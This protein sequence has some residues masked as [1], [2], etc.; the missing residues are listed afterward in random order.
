MEKNDINICFVTDDNYAKNVAI[1]ITSI[2]HNKKD[3]DSL[4]FYVI[5]NNI[6]Q[7]NKNIILSSIQKRAKLDFIDITRSKIYNEIMQL[8]QKSKYITKSSYFKFVIADILCDVDKVIYLDSDLIIKESLSDLYNVDLE[9]YLFGAVEDMGYTYWQ[10]HSKEKMLDFLCINSGVL[11]IDCVKWREQNLSEQLI[12]ATLNP[13]IRKCFGQDQPVFNYVCKDKIKFLDYKWNAQDSFFRDKPEKA[14]HINK[15]AITKAA[16]NPAIIHYTGARK[17]WNDNTVQ[18]A[19]EW[20]FYRKLL[21][22]IKPTKDKL[23]IYLIT[24][25]RANCLENTFKQ[26]FAQDSPIKDFDIT[27]LDNVSTDNTDEI[28]KKYQEKFPN[29]VHIKHEINCGGGVNLCK[30]Y[31]LAA[32]CEKEYA[33]VLCDDDVFCFKGWK[34]VENAISEEK[35]IICVSNYSIAKGELENLAYIIPQL[36][37]VPACIFKTSII[38]K[39]TLF[40]MYECLYTLFPQLW[41]VIQIVNNQGKIYTVKEGIVDNGLHY[42][43]SSEYASYTRDMK[44]IQL[45]DRLNK[46]NWILGFSELTNSLEDK[47]LQKQCV[48]NSIVYKDIYG[49]WT[50]FYS[51][52]YKQFLNLNDFNYFYGIYKC[53]R[54]RRKIQFL[55][56]FVLCK[57]HLQKIINVTK[58]IRKIIL[59]K[60]VICKKN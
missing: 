19:E 40:S 13:E 25:N 57:L 26:I 42:G 8:K 17:P 12:N 58:A 6:T 41:P 38:T 55:L 34:E 23:Q 47:K 20:K 18:K 11:L 39:E 54:F 32:V 56:I 50:N 33:W 10:K 28:I 30:A 45:P 60:L 22:N 21:N 36:S 24:Y 37:F 31:E 16:N 2:K 35:D 49:S 1:T 46:R 44:K 9:N 53:L 59:Y 15:D 14:N 4:H 27:V 5:H 48:E 52:F 3:N 43:C 29:L 51:C 7:N